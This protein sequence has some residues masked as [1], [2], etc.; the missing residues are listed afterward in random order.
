MTKFVT[1]DCALVVS[2]V[3]VTVELPVVS[4]LRL[5]PLMTA[6]TVVEALLTVTPL[7][8]SAASSAAR[9]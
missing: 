7:T 4:R 6:L 2:A 1:A 8:V 5:T 3:T 9:T